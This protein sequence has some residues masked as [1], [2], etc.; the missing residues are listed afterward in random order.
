VETSARVDCGT[1]RTLKTL[2]ERVVRLQQESVLEAQHHSTFGGA[3]VQ[4]SNRD[5]YPVRSVPTARAGAELRIGNLPEVDPPSGP[6]PVPTRRK[7][8]QPRPHGGGKS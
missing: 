7:K 4:K 2:L 1:L 5:M 8:L 3:D 6:T